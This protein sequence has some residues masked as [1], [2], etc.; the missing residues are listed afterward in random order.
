MNRRLITGHGP[1]NM[2]YI[3]RIEETITRALRE[4]PRTMAV[5][6]DLRLPDSGQ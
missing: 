2:D 3:E 5:R 1:L 4:H 6:V